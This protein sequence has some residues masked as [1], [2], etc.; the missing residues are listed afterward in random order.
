M[1]LKITI[2]F[3]ACKQKM[4]IH[5]Y[6]LIRAFG[7]VTPGVCP[8]PQGT[9]NLIFYFVTFPIFVVSILFLG[10]GVLQNIGGLGNSNNTSNIKAPLSFDIAFTSAWL[11]LSILAGIH[12]F[13]VLIIPL[14]M[15][16]S[17][18][19]LA[20]PAI[21]LFNHP[22]RKAV[23]TL[24]S[25]LFKNQS[26]IFRLIRILVIMLL[27]IFFLG[28]E[29]TI[30]FDTAY[31]HLPIARIFEEFGAIKGLVT[32]HIN[33]GQIS[34]WLVFGAP[35]TAGGELGWGSSIANTFIC[36]LAAVQA[37]FALNHIVDGS[38]RLCDFIAGIGFPLVLLLA[39]RWGMISSLSPDVPAMLL[40]VVIAWLLSLSWGRQSIFFAIPVAA[41]A[42][43]IKLSALPIGLAT[44]IA[45]LY[46]IRRES[47]VFILGVSLGLAIFVPFIW[48]SLVS[49]GCFAF[50]MSLTC[51][52]FPWTPSIEQLSIH[53][54]TIIDAA[55]GGGR[56]LPADTPIVTQFV[57]W[58]SRDKSGAFIILSGLIGVLISTIIILRN[59]A[60]DKHHCTDEIAF[61]APYALAVFGL[62][63]VS[64]MAPTGRF[65]GGYT[66]VLVAIFVAITPKLEF[67]FRKLAA[68]WL[69]PLGFATGIIALHITGPGGATREMVAEQ[70]ATGNFP[71]PGNGI[72]LPKRLI[73]FDI[74]HPETSRLRKWR[75][76][77]QGSV[78]FT[79]ATTTGECW[80]A[81]P[82]CLPQGAQTQL[83][84]IDP[85]HGIRGGLY[86]G[87]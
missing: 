5:R 61:F 13:V 85:D 16:I 79:K 41:F 32:L 20:L 10:I 29:Q 11:G 17:I 63:Y 37:A 77:T 28:S 78:K 67:H 84:Y 62:I 75:Q 82:P 35:G 73:P 7:C 53:T 86:V 72:L 65:A 56:A 70:V 68:I 43:T 76:S 22:F 38:R 58:A 44:G 8:I 42:M 34:S 39:A 15:E 60:N 80:A 50:P 87:K 71:D 14:S 9:A 69:L 51:F 12:S 54:A 23:T 52:E 27:P 4:P 74:H 6:S 48:L 25:G 3:L 57:T 59:L 81:P 36:L 46:V 21:G 40:A 31:Y 1:S 18:L 83:K 45:A 19:I 30:L 66:S 24:L 26:S 47:R 2:A 64:T 55:R 33:F 49:T